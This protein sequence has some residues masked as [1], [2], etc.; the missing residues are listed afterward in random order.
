M[1][2]IKIGEQIERFK[3][4]KHDWD[5]Y[6]AN[7]IDSHVAENTINVIQ[8]ISLKALK[9]LS[10]IFLNPNGTL[11]LLWE[12]ESFKL[13]SLEVGSS[14]F[15]YYIKLKGQETIYRNN[16]KLNDEDIKR[17]DNDIQEMYK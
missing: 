14:S 10:D 3:H 6:G 11:S 17:L 16:I 5:G 2:E 12:I 1:D 15:S 7:P 13:I 8:K 9:L 4:L